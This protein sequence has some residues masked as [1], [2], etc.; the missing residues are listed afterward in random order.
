[1]TNL[2]ANTPKPTPAT[3]HPTT[4]IAAANAVPPNPPKEAT[5]ALTPTADVPI[6]IPL[7]VS[8]AIYRVLSSSLIFEIS[9]A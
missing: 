6:E 8:Y 7:V 1:M 9:I 2:A 4:G 5:V 3:H